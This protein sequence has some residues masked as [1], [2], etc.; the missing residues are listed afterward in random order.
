[1]RVQLRLCF[2]S[3]YLHCAVG[4]SSII[5]AT[6]LLSSCYFRSYIVEK[7]N[8]HLDLESTHAFNELLIN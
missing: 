3:V 2:F 4:L 8:I 6:C 1:M 5:K 7:K